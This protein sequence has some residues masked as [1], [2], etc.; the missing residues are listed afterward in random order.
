MTQKQKLSELM[1]QGAKELLPYVGDYISEDGYACALGCAIYAA[2]ATDIEQ[3][4]AIT[5]DAMN[6]RIDVEDL[7]KDVLGEH[8]LVNED[9]TVILHDLIFGTN[10]NISRARA[11]EITKALGY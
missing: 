4:Y 2:N 11:I 7:P 6:I 1:E 3:V 5:I 9:G 8:L 10:D